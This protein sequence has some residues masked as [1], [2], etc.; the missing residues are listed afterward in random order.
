M[1]IQIQIGNVTLN[2]ILYDTPSGRE[3]YNTLPLS[4]K[5]ITWG[6]EAYFSIPVQ[7][8]LDETACETVS[9]GDI[10]FWPS[11]QCFCIFFGQQPISA[12]NVCG[13]ITSDLSLL[14]SIKN[15]EKITISAT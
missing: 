4:D 12:V 9:E 6:N 13:K 1:D 14:N 2:A 15:D 3:I 11:G 10:G 5:I 7:Q 8:Q